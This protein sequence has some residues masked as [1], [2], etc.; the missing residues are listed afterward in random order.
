VA[1]LKT[2]NVSSVMLSNLVNNCWIFRSLVN[3]FADTITVRHN[4]NQI[5]KISAPLT[6]VVVGVLMLVFVAGDPSRSAKLANS[7]NLNSVST[8]TSPATLEPD[9]ITAQKVLEVAGPAPAPFLKQAGV[10]L[11]KSILI[12]NSA[13]RLEKIRA[14][15]DQVSGKGYINGEISEEGLV[16]T[17][18]GCKLAAVAAEPFEAMVASA[19]AAGFN[20]EISGC[21]RS[22]ANQV[23][24]RDKWCNRDLCNFGAVPG[25]SKHG[26][27]L[28]VDFKVGKR[29]ISFQDP[30]FLW[31][32][33][34]S[35]Q[36]G[37]FHPYWAGEK[38]SAKEPWHWEFGERTDS[39]SLAKAGEIG[40]V[41]SSLIVPSSDRST[42]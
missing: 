32:L 22:F 17:S 5:W 29:A 25:T 19:R 3:V 2:N 28:A 30:V 10:A 27:G 41:D 6:G 33:A 39:E 9:L 26:K 42:S 4:M 8:P 35:E 7:D 40:R 13:E 24:N 11:G 1:L 38:G 23:I 12:E 31:L 16:K 34:N 18:N 14:L 21:Y 37:F 15:A 20:L 36:Y